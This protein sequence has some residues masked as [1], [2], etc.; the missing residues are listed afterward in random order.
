[1][2]GV[3][4]AMLTLLVVYDSLVID[5][6]VIGIIRPKFLKLPD[7]MDLAEMKIH[8]KKT[9]IVCWFAII[10]GSLLATWLFQL[11]FVY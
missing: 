7:Q 9:F 5:L 11:I 2:A 4:F 3:N 6:W 10:P 8:V 1:M